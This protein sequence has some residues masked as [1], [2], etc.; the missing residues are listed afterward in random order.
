MARPQILTWNQDCVRGAPE[1]LEDGSVDL[2][3]TDPPYGIGGDKL[4]AHY[5]RDESFVVDGYVE[6]DAAQ[7]APFTRAWLAQA[8]RVLRPGGSFYIVS[9]WTRLREVLDALHETPLTL[10]NHLVWKYHFGV[11]TRLKYVTSHYHI[12]YG[13]KPGGKPVFNTH[14]R[15]GPQERD[16]RGRSLLYRDLE[17]VWEIPRVYKPGQVKNKNELPQ[18]LLVKMIQYSSRPGDRVCDFFLGGFTTLRV[19]RGMGREGCGFEL[20]PKAYRS[21]LEAL[22]RVKPGSLLAGLRTP[23][24]DAPPNQH[25]PWSPRERRELHARFSSHRK[26]GL[27]KRAA[28]QALGEEFG[29]GRFAIMNSLEAPAKKHDAD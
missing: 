25:R 26:A 6:V 24:P 13:T 29:R 12:L 27:T 14:D 7:Y 23:N 22:E 8:S 10:V 28:I 5:H 21:G 19:A 16:E 18:E 20:N 3:I 15:F 9:G 2:F 11:N 1:R 4:H 17:D